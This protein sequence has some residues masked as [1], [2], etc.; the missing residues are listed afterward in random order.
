MKQLLEDMIRFAADGAPEGSP[1][2][3]AKADAD[4]KAKADADAQAKLD[5]EEADKTVPYARFKEVNERLADLTKLMDKNKKDADAAA[6]AK[7]EKD[8]EFEKLYASETK[9]KEEA[10]LKLMRLQVGVEK[11]LPLALI[12]RLQGTTAAEL[13]A[14]AE[15]LK[16]LVP[17]DGQLN[18]PS[19]DPR[20]KQS[21]QLD[22]SSM[23][24]AQVRENTAKLL[25]EI[26]AG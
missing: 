8:G 4:A 12:N 16:A 26:E 14:D 1:E 19:A 2:D 18:T 6:K 22:I 24:P 23:T 11:G 7:A 10:E 17:A 25:D 9:A 13:E 5:A 21:T 3:K 15:Q 20:R